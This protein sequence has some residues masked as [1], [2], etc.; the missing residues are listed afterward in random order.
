MGVVRYILHS[1][2]SCVL[3]SLTSFFI[4]DK[5]VGSRVEF[6]NVCHVQVATIGLRKSEK[7]SPSFHMFLGR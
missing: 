2:T 6:V 7:V 4:C 5:G 1:A 3:M